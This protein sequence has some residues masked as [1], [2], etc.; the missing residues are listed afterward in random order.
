MIRIFLE[1]RK[2]ET[3]EY[4]FIE[5]LL[6]RLGYTE[7]VKDMLICVNGKDNLRNAV[8]AFK[9]NTLN[10]GVN[11]IVFDADS[12]S[13]G[14]G[15]D[16]RKE[17]LEE[18]IAR[19][20]IEAELFLFPDNRS[21][22]ALEDL[23]LELTQKERWHGFFDCFN[24]YELC[25]GDEYVHPNLKGKLYTYISSMK[26]LTSGQRSRLGQGEWLFDDDMYWNLEHEK[27][28]PLKEFLLRWIPIA[29]AGE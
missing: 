4:V 14:G 11:L 16:S 25:L 28:R 13:N 23:L 8:N 3:Q 20:G 12:P 17:E 1:T 26:A 29:S 10:G 27:L 21:D 24:D 22:G 19:L 9:T 2:R 18:E 15:F 6:R 5:T 7:S